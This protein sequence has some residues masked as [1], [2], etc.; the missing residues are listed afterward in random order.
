MKKQ[1]KFLEVTLVI[2]TGREDMDAISAGSERANSYLSL[3]RK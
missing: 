1:L 2:E 3:A